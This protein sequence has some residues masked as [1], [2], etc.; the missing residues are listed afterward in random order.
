MERRRVLVSGGFGH[1]D[2]RFSFF[3]RI[4]EA[5][6][7]RGWQVGRFDA[8]GDA[9]PP[10]LLEKAAERL[11]TLPGRWM[12][13]P[14]DRVR[15]ALPWTADGRREHA[16]VEAVREFSPE[17]LIVISSVRFQPE[18][19]VRCRALGVREAVGWYVEGP[20][21]LGM[22]ETESRLYDRYYCIHREIE[23]ASRGR[24]GVLP[25]YGLDAATFH[26]LRALGTPRAPR[27]RIAFVGAPSRR[28]LRY[29]AALRGLPLDLWG[30]GWSLQRAFA[31]LHRGEALWGEPLNAVYND[32]AIVLNVSSWEPQRSGMTQRIVEVPASGAF[33][34]TD[35][36]EEARDLYAVGDQIAVF[37][38]PEDL[39]AKCEYYLAHAEER[40]VIAGRGHRRALALPDYAATASVLIGSAP[41]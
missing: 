34:L 10:Q 8:L 28:R 6:E 41:A 35:D 15:A 1:A 7:A 22:P 32:S 17:V 27:P 9:K 21:D 11:F 39:R 26:P 23:V 25:S 30:P 13:V 18:T 37:T 33:L 36:A 38:D 19:L 16:L 31:P 4:A 14:K 29:V 20:V 40:E 5:L 3:E 12:G 2:H 24:I